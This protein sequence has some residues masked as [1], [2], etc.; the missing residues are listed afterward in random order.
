MAVPA[1]SDTVLIR[2]LGPPAW[3]R[4]GVGRGDGGGDDAGLGNAAPQP[5]SRKDAALFAVLALEGPQSRERLAALLWPDVPS[6]RATSNLRQ[7]LF[8]LRQQTG[9]AL[10]DSGELLRPA[11]GLSFD[12]SALAEARGEGGAALADELLGAL[13]YADDGDLLERWVQQA[14]AQ[15]RERRVDLLTGLAAGQESRGELAAALAT[16]QRLL[17]ID[18]LLE[19][20]WRRQMRLHHLRGDRAA[21]VASFERCEQVLKDEL[22]LRPSP[23]TQ[24]LLAEIERGDCRLPPQRRLLPPGLIRPPQ[25]V[26]R[27]ATWADMQ[28]AWQAGRPFLLLGAAG[29]GKTR[30]LGDWARVEGDTLL[31]AALPGDER[32]P[33]AT[34]ARVLRRAFSL[35]TLNLPAPLR[36]ELSRLL[37]ELG[38]APE[39]AADEAQLL[40]SLDQALHL[41][42]QGGWRGLLLDDLHHADV[43]TLAVLHRHAG[44]ADGLGLGFSCRPEGA[45][46]AGLPGHLLTDSVR[47]VPLPLAPLSDADSQALL[48]MLLQALPPERLGPDAQARAVQV[49]ALVQ[50]LCRHGAGNPF[51]MIE[52]LKAWLSAGASAGQPLPLAP[53]VSALIEQR[54]RPLS[55][56]ALALARVAALAGADFNAELAAQVMAC[57]VLALADAW[58]ELEALQLLRPDGFANE[59]MRVAVHD[60]VPQ[61]VRTSLHR[62]VAWALRAL[63]AAPER[64]AWHHAQAGEWAEAGRA[65]RLAA[66]AACRLGRRELQLL[67]L[68]QA[69]EW[70]TQAGQRAEALDARLASVEVCEVIEG[71][72]AALALVQQ[73]LADPLLADTVLPA[74]RRRLARLHTLASH[75]LNDLGDFDAALAHARSATA[76]SDPDDET[77]WRAR[78]ILAIN[79]AMTGATDEAVRGMAEV[80]ASARRLAE[81]G[82]LIDLLNDQAYVL[83]YASRRREAVR[84]L[85]ALLDLW[86]QPDRP[87]TEEYVALG[88]L[89][90]QYAVLGRQDDALAAGLRAQAVAQALGPTLDSRNSEVNLALYLMGAGR[91]HDALALLED[92]WRY[93]CRQAPGTA[94]QHCAEEFLAEYWLALGRADRAAE[95]LSHTPLAEVASVRRAFRLDLLAR[96]AT[97][98]DAPALW[99]QALTAAEAGAPM[100]TQ[101]RV[102]LNASLAM[103]P[104]EALAACE[105]ARQAAQAGEYPPGELL[106]HLRLAQAW[107][108]QGDVAQACE[109]ADAAW[110]LHSAG[111]RHVFIAPLELHGVGWSAWQAAANAARAAQ[112]AGRAD[113]AAADSAA[114]SV[115]ATAATAADSRAQA[116]RQAGLAWLAQLQA[117]PQAPAEE[118]L[119]SLCQTDWARRLAQGQ[120]EA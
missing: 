95:A 53:S 117:S 48:H 57:P 6:A 35:D 55:A 104:A 7:R 79:L 110:R 76:G 78:S 39:R 100:P 75:V 89:A 111:V 80:V 74:T 47:A 94:L 49:P 103:P 41:L 59:L 115:V 15:W 28:A 21:A 19:H 87:S 23:E 106:A 88:N 101:V 13:D 46:G 10:I 62:R 14:R 71:P 85:E 8:R 20:A 16:V 66:Q 17:S 5:L 36:S 67:Q 33:Y 2:L 119:A 34:L 90:V 26:G 105:Q 108:R 3:V 109:Q 96:L 93:A 58:A 37:P 69:A 24:D 63:G 65:E 9:H 32:V 107:L 11:E 22:G 42:R 118:D 18:P 99:A 102:R 73:L 61:A 114:P 30:L 120:S 97:P 98:A 72:Q 51:F 77:G 68:R 60:G 31:E 86:A 70:L 112:A 81:R 84:V 4:T 56:E 83:N 64:A 12:F 54:L 1:Q 45:G 82:V 91:L 44:S 50:A 113:K 25:R 27:D 29:L 116:H 52:T 43:A 38:A 92:I 40:F